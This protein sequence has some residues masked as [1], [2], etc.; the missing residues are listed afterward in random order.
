MA[1]HW[2]IGLIEG[3]DMVEKKNR[4]LTSKELEVLPVASG[5][6]LT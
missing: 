6:C 2:A 4:L 3:I 1:G 5:K